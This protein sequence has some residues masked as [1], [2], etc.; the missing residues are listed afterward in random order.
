VATGITAAE[1][2]QRTALLDVQSYQVL[3]DLT[4][5]SDR[6]YSATAITFDCREPGAS[7]FADLTADRVG[8]A[9]LN[10]TRL[11]TAAVPAEGRLVLPG[12]A[13]SNVLLVDA[14]VAYSRSGYGLSRFTD[15]ADGET[16]LLANCFPTSAP[17]IFCC[18][19]QPDLR[20]EVTL[21]VRAPAG[22]EC[23]SNGAVVARPPDG[24]AGDWRFAPVPA[25]K[26]Y[27][28][29]LC[30]GPYVTVP[31]ASTSGRVRQTVRCRPALAGSPGLARI[32]DI[33][34]ATLAWYEEFLGVRCPC[35]RLEIIFAPGLGPQA[36]QLPAVMYVSE[37][38]LSR[39]AD[40]ADDFPPTVLAHELAHL[41]FGC[42]VEGRWW[43]DL[44]LAEALASYLSYLAGTEALGVATAWAQFAMQGQ[45]SAYRADSLPGSQPVASPVSTAADALTRPAAIT[46][47]K[48]T[49][50]IRQLSALIGAEALQTGLRTYLTT[51][52]WS[53][54]TL[55]DL[56]G[57][58]AAAS[59]QDLTQWAQ[60][61]LRE[62][63]TSILRP[64]LTLRPDGTV[65]SLVIVQEAP[66]RDGTRAPLRR[67]RLAV[68]VYETERGRLH[69]SRLIDMVVSGERTEVPGLAGVP[70]PR[71]FVL[72]DGDQTF[73]RIRFDEQSL[74][75]LAGS[76]FSLSDPLTEA[77]CWNAA[78]DM[79][80][81]A[82]LTAAD[83]T[84]L[85]VRRI[86][87]GA[88][89]PAVTEL[90]GFAGSAANYYAPPG[91]RCRLLEELAAA[92]LDA[93]RQAAPGSPAR[94]A[95]V[96]GFAACAQ[97]KDQLGLLRAW[98][99][100][101]A[102]A[103]S[104]P[105]GDL[106]ARDD[107]EVRRKALATLAAHGQATDQDLDTLVADDPVGGEAE[108]ATCRA[109]RPDRAAKQ[110]AWTAAL[111]PDL[112]PRLARAHAQGIWAPGQDDVVAPFRERFFAEALPALAGREH[113]AAEQLAR[114]LYPA[115]MADARTVAATDE[116]LDAAGLPDSLRQVLA[117]QRAILRQVIAA[118][119]C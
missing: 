43:D 36:M 118:R 63:G 59:G 96:R 116:A 38:F 2:A 88:P 115:T 100:A 97:S 37:T 30:A 76:A 95:L 92:A 16:Y 13:A 29:T 105:A 20:A 108:R 85:V 42:L 93:A 111:S 14:E 94:Q 74:A 90:L 1:A 57:C 107:L 113:R 72:N 114:L 27:E 51:Y 102:D 60:Q 52:A 83:F 64:E 80:T 73:A 33:V 119:A 86:R 34:S 89:L 35:D 28:L 3:L 9:S 78:W 99:G 11:D 79:T 104:D 61:W 26:P 55:D 110:A 75:A 15:P 87:D 50:V 31:A 106:G 19:D 24:Q 22:W 81:A 109:L 69:R 67:H 66:L 44:W 82:E 21:T 91:Q 7:A 62:P 103:A 54:T 49:S 4:A 5:E 53:A 40:A 10:G 12:L 17:A 101:G 25:I 47:S 32:S 71:A 8:W 112:F 70:A 77:V 46:Y 117:E 6:A 56:I 39:L 23:V 41:W 58:W 48:G 65:Q 45:A 68:G 18:F 98:I 84:D